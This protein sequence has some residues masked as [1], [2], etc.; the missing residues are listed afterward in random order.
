MA[1]YKHRHTFKKLCISYKDQ[2][3]RTCMFLAS[4]L[5]S[6]IKYLAKSK[7]IVQNWT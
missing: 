1:T 4:E 6:T 3:K 2:M 7:E 5:P